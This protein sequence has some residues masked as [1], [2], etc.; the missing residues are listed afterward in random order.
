MEKTIVAICYDFD[1]TLTVKEMQEFS[2]IPNLGMTAEEFW[3][4]SNTYS[5]N[6]EMDMILGLLKTMIDECKMRGI[7]LTREYLKKQGEN[8]KF[9]DGVTTWFKRMNEYAANKNIEL[10]HYI[11]S[12]GNKEI[13]EG[14]SIFKEFKNVF[15]CEFLYDENG[16]A[17]WPKTIVNYTQ[18]TQYLF[19]IN[20]GA[21]D[22]S[23]NEKVNQR[24]N[25]KHVEFRNMIYVGDGST[26]IPCMT[27]VKEKGGVAIS[28]YGV[29]GE[30]QSN[31]L[32]QDDRVNY[33]CKGDFRSGSEL[34]KLMKLIIDSM[35][36]KEQLT[37]KE[38]KRKI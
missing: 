16:E 35:S 10:E 27:L 1:K 7:K 17:C 22:L 28:I 24:V 8:I 5:K 6:N 20:K 9:Y 23:D 21:S 18:K 36:L 2:F 3:N 38:N 31:R 12:S 33:A 4:K 11:I 13:I 26:D 30:E 19:R 32:L 37:Q 34:E 25:R 14:S 15:G 29:G